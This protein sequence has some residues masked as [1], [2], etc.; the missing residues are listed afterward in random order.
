M[1]GAIS[2]ILTEDTATARRRLLAGLPSNLADVFDPPA[3]R[4]DA[5]IGR[6]RSRSP[7]SF[8]GRGRNPQ[9]AVLRRSPLDNDATTQ[10]PLAAS[11]DAACDAAGF[12]ILSRRLRLALAH[13]CG[14]IG[15]AGKRAHRMH[16]SATDPARPRTNVA[17]GNPMGSSTTG[18]APGIRI[19]LAAPADAATVHR[20]MHAAFDEFRGRLEPPSSAHGETVEDVE[21]AMAAGGAVIA[22]EGDEAVG[23]ARFQRQPGRLSVGRVAVLPGHRGRGI[24]RAMMR[25]IAGLAPGMGVDELRV[26]VRK[27]LPG[28]VALYESLGY[29]VVAEYAHPRDPRFSSLVMALRLPMPAGTAADERPLGERSPPDCRP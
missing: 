17:G 6:G 1:S 10:R 7:T 22:W 13:D 19:A 23:C 16:P 26:E 9:D 2:R 18:D 21:R 28:N 8:A 3:D 20:V 11:R 15:S 4:A 14:A 29:A 27:S 5:A 12:R 24:A 25:A